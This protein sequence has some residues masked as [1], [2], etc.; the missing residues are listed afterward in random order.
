MLTHSCHRMCQDEQRIRNLQDFHAA[1]KKYRGSVMFGYRST[2]LVNY[3]DASGG[4]KGKGKGTCA[5]GS[6]VQGRHLE[7]RKYGILKLRFWRIG[8]C[9]ADSVIFTPHNTLPVL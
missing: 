4:R 3:S 1:R 6:T 7:E 5:P 8:V 2:H 9:P